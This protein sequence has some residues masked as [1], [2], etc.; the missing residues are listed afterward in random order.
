MTYY[1]DPS[2]FYLINVCT[3]I[4]GVAVALLVVSLAIFISRA[5][6]YFADYDYLQDNEKDQYKKGVKMVTPAILI[7]VLLIVFVPSKQ[8]CV[9]MLIAKTVTV[10]NLNTT[11]DGTKELIDYIFEKVNAK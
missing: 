5:I 11:I 9:E 2:L 3:G 1:V 4:R 10:E 8:T 6:C 7:S